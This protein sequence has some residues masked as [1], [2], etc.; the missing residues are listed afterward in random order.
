MVRK[1]IEAMFKDAKT[2]GFELGVDHITV[3]IDGVDGLSVRDALDGREISPGGPKVQVM[4]FLEDRH[5]MTVVFGN[6]GETL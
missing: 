4:D 3:L 6:I 2:S 1:E 5:S